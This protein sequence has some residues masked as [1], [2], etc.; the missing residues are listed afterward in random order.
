[1]GKPKKK[2]KTFDY[3]KN[4][5]RAWKKSQKLPSIGC[6]Q[7]K[8]AWDNKKSLKQNLKDMGL[9]YDPNQ[10]LAIPKA[11]DLIAGKMEVEEMP[12]SAI[13]KG[14]VVQELESEANQPQAKTLKFSEPEVRFCI[15]MMEKYG[16]EYKKM[17]RDDKNYYQETPKQIRRK[18]RTFMNIP[19]QYKAYLKSKEANMDTE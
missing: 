6:E 12:I 14:K 8:N 3:N 13:K 18:I 17:A 5:R 4:R 2:T 1:M 19:D 7:V 11:K 10:T 15:Y 16:E 9:S